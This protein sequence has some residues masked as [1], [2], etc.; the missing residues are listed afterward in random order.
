MTLVATDVLG[1]A[2][3]LVALMGEWASRGEFAMPGFIK[4][5]PLREHQNNL[6]G[7][8]RVCRCVRFPVAQVEAGALFVGQSHGGV[9]R[10]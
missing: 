9:P 8:L 6:I 2:V 1:S 4:R 5:S 7:A 3:V 10:K